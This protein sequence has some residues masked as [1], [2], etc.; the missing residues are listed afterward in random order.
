MKRRINIIM[1]LVVCIACA[2]AFVACG[3]GSDSVDVNVDK[4]VS[5]A[6]EQHEVKGQ[7]TKQNY[8]VDEEFSAAD[9]L[10]NLKVYD[11][12]QN[13][14][15]WYLACPLSD[16][17][18]SIRYEVTEFD[19][20][21]ITADSE[22]RYVHIVFTSDKYAGKLTAALPISVLEPYAVECEPEVGAQYIKD[23]YAVG[24]TLP[25][26]EMT[27]KVTYSN[28]KS[29]TVAMTDENVSIDGFDT[30]TVDVSKRTAHIRYLRASYSFNYVVAPTENYTLFED[31]FIKCFVPTEGLGFKKSTTSYDNDFLSKWLC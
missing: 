10:V 19:T 27:L 13:K 11:K 16:I 5:V 7:K 23:I 17:P 25:I 6:I 21:T 9:T 30:D 22:Y 12:E 8:Y 28:G 3:S 4:F 24:D 26:E 29:D 2:F 15:L 1:L 18:N 20:S 31:L 14:E